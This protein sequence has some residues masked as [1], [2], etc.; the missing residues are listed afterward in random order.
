M[1]KVKDQDTVKVHYTGR[2]TDGQ[3]FDS[4]EGREPLEFKVGA[5]QMI[6]GFEKGV[7]DMAVNEEKTIEIPCEEAYGPVNEDLIQKVEKNKLPEG[8]N[9]TVGMKLMSQTESGHQIPITVTEVGE[10]F[11]IIDANHQLAGKDLVFD[12][13]LVEIS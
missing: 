5:G 7:L 13:K 2:L 8:L 1:E 9:P 6:K 12:I 4:S 11:I 10:D 3:V